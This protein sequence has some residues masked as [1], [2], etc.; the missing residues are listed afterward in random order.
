[1][2]RIVEPELLDMLPWNDPQALRSRADL[3]RVNVLMN[4]SKALARYL[5]AHLSQFGG[6]RPHLKI[7]EIGAGDG[8]VLLAVAKRLRCFGTTA[9]VLLIDNQPVF[10]EVTRAALAAIGWEVK[11]TVA[12]VLTDL[13]PLFAHADVVISN[14]FLHQ[15]QDHA[16][17]QMFAQIS[18]K[19]DL[20]V[21]I[22]P[23]RSRPIMMAGSLLWLL[24]CSAVTRHDGAVSIRAGFRDREMS[25]LW[26]DTAAW[27]L[28]EGPANL[29][30]HGFVA[31]RKASIK[32]A[33][34]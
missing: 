16:L 34:A 15:F 31:R 26:P 14:M 28:D 27:K 29:F 2:D 1:M 21:A 24:G 9:E 12:D 6:P 32:T 20:V 7:V 30:N 25:S 11:L 18:G 19:T 8:T 23:R 13:G 4:N 10:A 33:M 22:E 3:R 17:R 5:Q